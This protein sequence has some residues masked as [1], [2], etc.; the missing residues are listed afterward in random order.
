[1]TRQQCLYN[2][3]CA[4]VYYMVSEP[5]GNVYIHTRGGRKPTAAKAKGRV[6][7]CVCVCVCKYIYIYILLYYALVYG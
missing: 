4:C 7:V 1:M 2:I 3:M 5:F 6:R